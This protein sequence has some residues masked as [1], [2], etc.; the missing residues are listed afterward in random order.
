M[1][2]KLYLKIGS[3]PS[4][5]LVIENIDPFHLELFR[6]PEGNV[7]IS[8]LN[9]EKGTRVNSTKLMDFIQLNE[10]DRVY[11]AENIFFDWKEILERYDTPNKK[12]KDSDKKT[13]DIVSVGNQK[14]KK[15]DYIEIAIV[16][17]AI[18]LMLFLLSLWL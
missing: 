12:S 13:N 4:N 14:S 3:D 5:D 2:K 16:Y 8:D 9:T 7:F 18:L 17:G 11:L 15:Q 1:S 10:N 6:D